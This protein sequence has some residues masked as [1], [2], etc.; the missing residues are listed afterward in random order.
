MKKRLTIAALLMLL[1]L[2]AAAP[3]LA[4]DIFRFAQ[5]SVD[6][7]D[8]ESVT[9]ELIREGRYAE[10]EVVYHV[11]GAHCTVD[12]NGAITGIDEG[13][14]YVQADLYQN[15]KKVK[16]A[17]ILVKVT[18]KAAKIVLNNRN[19]QIYEPDDETILEQLDRAA[20]DPPIETQILVIPT[21]RRIN[22]QPTVTPQSVRNKRVTLTSGD[23][24]ILSVSNDGG[25]TGIKRGE[26]EL[27]I[28]SVQAPEVT[29]SFH[30]LVVQPVRKVTVSGEKTVAAGKSIQLTA[31]VAPEDATVKAVEWRSRQAQTAVV[32]PNGLVTGVARGNTVIEAVAADGSGVTGTFYISVTQD[33]T[34]IVFKETDATVATGRR[35]RVNADVFPNNANNRRVIW[36]SSD[37]TIATVRDGVITGQKAGTC[38]ITC[39]SESN[40]EVTATIPVQVIQLVTDITVQT[41]KEA[42]SFYIGQSIQLDW[43]VMPEDASIKAVTF[44]SRRPGV[45]IVDENGTVTGVTKGEAYI[46]IKATDGSGRVRTVKVSVLKAVEGINPLAA[47]YYVPLHRS[48]NIKATVYPSDASNQ[49]ILWSTSDEYIATVRSVGTSYG[50]VSGVNRG[51]TNLTATSEDGGFSTSTMLVVDDFDGLVRVISAR[52]DGDN[53]IRLELYNT[54]PEF[55]VRTVYFTV[56]CFDTQRQPLVVGTDG[57]STSFSGSYPLT[58]TPGETSRHGNFRFFNYQQPS[59]Y[60][61]MVEIRVTGYDF[62]N[63]QHWNIPE[64]RQARF[65]SQPSE[66]YGEPVPT[67][68]PQEAEADG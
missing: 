20:D 31:T 22:L 17:S 40:P 64:D 55:T 42:L 8:G 1:C 23:P 53:K 26:C 48:V 5:D 38:V 61:G 7:L 39:A 52:I 18:Q 57:V 58:L 11:R 34:A 29:L 67:P 9:P 60:F 65:V 59:W 2:L 44:S 13:K 12:E 68:E 41:P 10:G 63:G 37:E 15:G 47:E 45:A 32:D 28:A 25:L 54:S 27:T 51:R 16:Y 50:G 62:D 35:V 6:V 49:R 19:L 30:V 3:A 4:A 21:G 33:V 56:D 43:T 46:D 14:V 24:A 66:H 36:T